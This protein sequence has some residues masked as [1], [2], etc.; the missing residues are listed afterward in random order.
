MKKIWLVLTLLSCLILGAPMQAFCEEPQGEGVGSI[1]IIYENGIHYLEDPAFPGKRITLFCMNNELQWPHH[2]EGMH[3]GQVPGYVPGYLTPD[4]FDSPKE[5]EECMRRLSKILFAGYPYNGERLYKIVQDSSGYAPTVS[6]FNEMLIVPPVLQTAYPYLGHHD[7]SYADWQDANEQHLEELRRFVDDTIKLQINHSATSNGLTFRDVSSTPF[8]KA[9]FSIVN[10]NSGTPLDTFQYFYGAD[11]FVTEEEAYNATQDAVWHLLYS[12]GVADNDLEVMS[13]P[14][15]NVLFT[16]SERG[17]LLEREPSWS[18]ISLKGDLSFSYNPKDGMWHSGTLRIVEPDEYR[19]LYGLDLPKGMSALCDNL[20]YVYGNEDYELISDHEPTAD[21]VFRIEARF[22]WL[23]ALRQY[24]PATPAEFNGKQFQNM[25]GAVINTSTLTRS[26]QVSSDP[27]GSLSLTKRVVG[28]TGDAETFKL[29]VVLPDNPDLN[30]LFGDLE[31]HGGAAEVD[32]ADG[33][34]KTAHNLPAGARYVVEELLGEN[35]HLWR[36]SIDKAEGVV[37]ENDTVAITCTNE[38]AFSLSVAKLV[39]GA[40]A[41][42]SKR[43]AFDIFLSA[44]DGTPYSGELSYT[45]SVFAGHEDEAQAPASGM[46]RFANGVATV[47]LGHAQQV[48]IVGIPSGMT[49]R[50]QERSESSKGFSVAY[51]GTAEPAAGSM[52][53]DQAVVVINT[54]E[55]PPIPN[56]GP[57]PSPNPGPTPMPNPGPTPSP[58]SPESPTP[59]HHRQPHPTVPLRPDDELPQTSDDHMRDVELLILAAGICALA[60]VWSRRW[61]HAV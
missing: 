34:T 49:Y 3:E 53:A 17:G 14:L 58:G 55:V 20:T 12:Y 30:G 45:G 35:A 36:P 5:Y 59:P 15:S 4:D 6:E 42:S 25:V 32:I 1:P 23:E 11:Y 18:E 29:R 52:S 48:T 21:D 26:V 41:S 33:E 39:S 27:V 56:P 60:A 13:L 24:S 19:G 43:F 46:L 28:H 10:C 51:N 7:F 9:A 40:D 47:E 37:R 31:F 61:P 57:N 54:K 22:L 16:Y 8:Y 2:I 38:R 50:V 44:P